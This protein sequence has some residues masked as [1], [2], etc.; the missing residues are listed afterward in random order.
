MYSIPRK[1]YDYFERN[2]DTTGN[3]AA[4]DLGLPG[5]TVRRYRQYWKQGEAVP[6]IEEQR[7][8]SPIGQWAVFDIETT[9]LSATG[10]KGFMVCCSILPL[11]AEQPHTHSIK[12]EENSGDDKRLLSN[13]LSDLNQY[14]F[15][16]GHNINGYDLNWLDTRRKIHNLP[17]LRKWYVYDTLHVA[18]SLAYLTERKSLV[19]LCDALG[20]PCIKTS[21][22]P[23]AWNEIRSSD[24][25]EFDE[26]LKNIV[27]HCE[28]DVLS[29]RRLFECL[30]VDSFNLSKSPIKMWVRGNAPGISPN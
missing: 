24:K 9:D 25:F 28:Q 8:H 19:W 10:R 13:V 7:V 18:Q 14:D 3:A 26:S 20:V 16:V 27:Y 17:P 21:I 6:A 4:R 5:R 2:S 23:S 11:G 12:F 29:T 15:L 1:V 22:Y 30:W